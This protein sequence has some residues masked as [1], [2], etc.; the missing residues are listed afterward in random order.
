MVGYQVTFTF[1]VQQLAGTFA[2]QVNIQGYRTDGPVC[3][4]AFPVMS[5]VLSHQLS[6]CKKP[7]TAQANLAM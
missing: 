4:I 5:Y 1:T 2:L 6:G 7:E 3:D